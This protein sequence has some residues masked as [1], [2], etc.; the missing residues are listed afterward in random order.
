MVSKLTQ[1]LKHQA[2]LII[3]SLSSKENIW[4]ASFPRSGNTWL[5]CMLYD[6][7]IGQEEGFPQLLR[8]YIPDIHRQFEFLNLLRSKTLYVK[9]HFS[10]SPQYRKVVYLLRD[11][12]ATLYSFWR[13]EI[14]IKKN[15]I[16]LDNFIDREINS[17]G[18]YGRWDSH[19]LSYIN[20]GLSESQLLIIRYEDLLLDT[21]RILTQILEFGEQ[22]IYKENIQRVAAKYTNDLLK[23]QKINQELTD[24]QKVK[25]LYKIQTLKGLEKLTTQ[26]IRKIAHSPVGRVANHL[27]YTSYKNFYLE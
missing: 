6:V 27:G 4:L 23:R 21:S 26:Q 22:E 25:S 12:F 14:E 7:L 13:R 8:R 15:Q 5:R 9:T 3:S 19:V 18:V 1:I 16:S 10:Y 17:G 11:P 20:S 24:S 2:S